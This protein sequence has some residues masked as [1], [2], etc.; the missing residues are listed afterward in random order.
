MILFSIKKHFKTIASS[1]LIQKKKVVQID[2]LK[3]IQEAQAYLIKRY[4]DGLL[5]P[6]TPDER[7]RRFQNFERV[8]QLKKDNFRNHTREKKGANAGAGGETGAGGGDEEED[9]DQ[10]VLHTVRAVSRMN[11]RCPQ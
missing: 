6:L 9:A 5:T 2:W 1:F 11:V 7:A 3:A 8:G 10:Y 4:E